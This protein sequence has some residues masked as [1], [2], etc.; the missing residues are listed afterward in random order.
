[1]TSSFVFQDITTE[2]ET[3][4]K[5]TMKMMGLSSNM[6]WLAW[7]TKGIVMKEISVIAITFMMCS[8][9][10][11]EK[12]IF[13]NSN[14]IIIWLFFS[15]YVSAVIVFCFF[16]GV[17]FKKS[18]TAVT[19]GA[20]LFFV[21]F[22]PFVVFDENFYM[23]PYIVKLLYCMMLNAGMGQGLLILLVSESDEVGVGFTNLFSRSAG[24]NFSIGEVMVVMT[25]AALVQLM[26]TFYIEKVFTGDIGV[27]RSWHYPATSVIEFVRHRLGYSTIANRDEAMQERRYSGPDYEDEPENLKAGIRI[28]NLSKTFGNKVAVDKLCMNIYEDQITVL[29]GYVL[30]I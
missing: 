13:L 16:I 22:M 17:I 1:M 20:I 6:H 28:S 15:L 27:P 30:L 29:L 21:T 7:F 2:R 10:V 14:A 12:P 19:V 9:L 25:F 24:L 5:E 3:K 8:T 26:M 4:L 18:S 23:L 11:T